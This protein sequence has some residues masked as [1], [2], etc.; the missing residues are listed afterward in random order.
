MFITGG[1]S[2]GGGGGISTEAV[3]PT[4]NVV[5]LDLDTAQDHKVT[6]S[7]VCE[8]RP[9]GGTEAESHTVRIVNSGLS[10]VTLSSHFLFP[11]GAGPTL[12]TANGSISMISFTVHREGSTGIST[13]LLSGA[14]I[15][16]S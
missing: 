1:G 15:N 8:I 5:T 6:A 16:Y 3:T 2:G 11:S 14:S 12:P 10:T 9:E 7:G 4:A 13:Q